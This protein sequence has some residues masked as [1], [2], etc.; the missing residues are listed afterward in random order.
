M[1]LASSL[2]PNQWRLL[3]SS[4]Q[5]YL[6]S[7]IFSAGTSLIS[8]LKNPFFFIVLLPLSNSCPASTTKSPPT[9]RQSR[10]LQTGVSPVVTSSYLPTSY[11]TQK[12]IETPTSPV[13]KSS[14]LY[15]QK[16]RAF[17]LRKCWGLQEKQGPPVQESLGAFQKLPMVMPSIDLYS[18]ALRKSRRV[19]PTKGL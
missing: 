10:N 19:Q 7:F 16:S 14:H 11:I 17:G 1:K 5:L 4:P 2:F 12:Q 13:K 8:A 9:L 15:I 18:S 3:A 6:Q